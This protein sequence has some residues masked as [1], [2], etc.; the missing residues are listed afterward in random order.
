[1]ADDFDAEE[2]AFRDALRG[3]ADAEGFRPLDADDLPKPSVPRRDWTTAVAA[4]VVIG[5]VGLFGVWLLPILVQSSASTAG[6]PASA[7]EDAQ[8]STAAEDGGLGA[9]VPGPAPASAPAESGREADAGWR[10]ESYRDVIAQVPLDWGYGWAPK[11]DWCA[12]TESDPPKLPFVDLA[13]GIGVTLAIGC[14][15]TIPADRLVPHLV[16][17]PANE[18]PVDPPLPQGWGRHSRTLGQVTLT[19]VTDTDGAALAEQILNSAEQ[20]DVDHNGCPITAG[21]AD[22]ADLAALAGVPI[23]VCFYD[24]GDPG[25]VSSARLEGDAAATAW[26]AILAA[27]GGGGPDGRSDQCDPAIPPETWAVLL[28]DGARSA[29]RFAGCTGNG[30]LDTSVAGQSH[31]VTAELCSALLVPP[32]TPISGTGPAAELCLPV[33]IGR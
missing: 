9:P 32:V 19:V 22:E 8:A 26:E 12:A 30:L 21:D 20:V 2:R 14:D 25:L 10:W 29:F 6:A 7:S 15:G 3:A 16:F 33:V 28:I 31:R 27:P 4:I 1:M 5:V 24:R 17:S 23:T 11:S 18:V 13:R